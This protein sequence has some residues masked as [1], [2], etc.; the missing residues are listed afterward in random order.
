MRSE[1]MVVGW[2]LKAHVVCM[3]PL[4]IGHVGSLGQISLALGFVEAIVVNVKVIDSGV[5]HECHPLIQV[6]AVKV[7]GIAAK[8]SE[9]D[10]SG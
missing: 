10:N 1:V 8:Q 2:C 7:E 9:D 6:C 5:R 3:R 4:N